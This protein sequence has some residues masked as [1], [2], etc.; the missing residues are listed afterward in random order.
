MKV[1]FSCTGHANIL[2]THRNTLEFTKA[3]YV[4][5][6]GD[7][8]VGI[9]SDF[10]TEKLKKLKGKLKI[11]I[12]TKNTSDVVFADKN[13]EFSHETEM[14][15]RKTTFKDKRT[16]AINADKSAMQ[17]KRELV[18]DLMSGEKATITLEEISQK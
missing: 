7:C 10:D 1:K 2:C 8:I 5:K 16:F 9:N 3:D 6:R 12:K 18:K 4:T 11:T 13:E 14:V 15:I 17:L